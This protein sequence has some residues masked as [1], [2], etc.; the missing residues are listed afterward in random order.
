M[1]KLEKVLEV[2]HQMSKWHISQVQFLDDRHAVIRFSGP[3]TI[4]SE[5]V[6]IRLT[7]WDRV[8]GVK[9]EDKVS[10][11]YVRLKNKLEAKNAELNRAEKRTAA[12]KE[13]SYGDRTAYGK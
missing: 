7:L 9:L 10:R 1:N 2:L 4:G 5:H 6:Y 3:T 8:A 12:F 11:A 13:G